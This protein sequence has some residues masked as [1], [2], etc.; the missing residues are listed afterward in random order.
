MLS[1]SLSQHSA[2]VLYIDCFMYAE[3]PGGG[4]QQNAPMPSGRCLALGK[5]FNTKVNFEFSVVTG[6]IIVHMSRI[7]IGV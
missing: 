7:Q 1:A 2:K 3:C 5:M 4:S 6:S